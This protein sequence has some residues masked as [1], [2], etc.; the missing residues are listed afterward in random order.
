MNISTSG[1]LHLLGML[2]KYGFTLRL[3]PITP[4][5]SACSG[6]YNLEKAYSTPEGVHAT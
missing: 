1:N 5:L 4:P 6:V 2:K 3:L